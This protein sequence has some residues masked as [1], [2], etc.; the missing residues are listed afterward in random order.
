MIPS[1]DAGMKNSKTG[2]KDRSSLARDV[3]Q[4]AAVFVD[5]LAT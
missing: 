5:A 4:A 2:P 3:L 1:L